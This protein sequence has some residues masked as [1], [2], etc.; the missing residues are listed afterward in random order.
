MATCMG[1]I[2]ILQGGES[3]GI[4]PILGMEAYSRLGAGSK[5]DGGSTRKSSF[6]L[7]L[8]AQD[9]VGVRE[10]DQAGLLRDARR[11]LLQAAN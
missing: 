9:H 2:R 10:S 4:D 11:V 1:R 7:T 6:H 8:L 5:K 3:G